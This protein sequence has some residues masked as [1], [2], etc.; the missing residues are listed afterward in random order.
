MMPG[1]ARMAPGGRS[2]GKSA[3]TARR[4]RWSTTLGLLLGVAG[5]VR[6]AEPAPP[7]TVIASTAPALPAVTLGRPVPLPRAGPLP[8]A[9]PPTTRVP[10][11]CL[12]R[13]AT[14]D[15]RAPPTAPA[16]AEH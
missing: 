14:W 6:A 3:M 11:R 7:R 10:P 15:A 8:P 16:R 1:R 9:P 5:L 2:G 12:S 13:P 4:Y